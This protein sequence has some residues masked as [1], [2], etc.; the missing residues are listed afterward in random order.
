MQ[1]RV[2]IIQNDYQL[3]CSICIGMIS[4]KKRTPRQFLGFEDMQKEKE[5]EGDGETEGE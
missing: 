2:V 3:M 1:D 4:L 5:R